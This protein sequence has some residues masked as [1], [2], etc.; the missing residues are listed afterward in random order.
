VIS[1]E[2]FESA[3]SVTGFALQFVSSKADWHIEK[4]CPAHLNL[5]LFKFPISF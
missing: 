3:S 4:I 5:E 1:G 2:T